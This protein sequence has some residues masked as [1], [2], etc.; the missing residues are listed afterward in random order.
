MKKFIYAINGMKGARWWFQLS[1]SA[2][3][4]AATPAAATDVADSHTDTDT[5]RC[6]GVDENP[7]FIEQMQE[8]ASPGTPMV[9]TCDTGGE[10]LPF[11]QTPDGRRSRSLVA[12]YK[13]L[14]AGFK[15]V[16][17]VASGTIGW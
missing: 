1:R 17:H 8:L 5:N 7:K 16:Y 4:A 3:A 10:Y 12:I 9:V 15:D 2:A 11:G 13:L 14:T 6:P